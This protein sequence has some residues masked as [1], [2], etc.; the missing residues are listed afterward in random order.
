MAVFFNI[1]LQH[2]SLY[3]LFPVFLRPDSSKLLSLFSI[4][5]LCNTWLFLTFCKPMKEIEFKYEDIQ[6]KG[7][8][9]FMG[10][11]ILFSE[12]FYCIVVLADFTLY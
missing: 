6:G 2:I 10:R 3:L 9:M 4:L 8:E 5:Q 1:N 11:E 12:C 7:Q